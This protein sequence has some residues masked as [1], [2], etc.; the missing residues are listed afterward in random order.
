MIVSCPA[1]ESRFQVDEE[2][3]GYDGRIVRCGKCSNCWHQ[4]PEKDPRAG[5]ADVPPPP[6]RRRAAAPPKKKGKGVLVGWLLLLVFIGGV[7]A[8]GWFERARIVTQFPQLADVYNLLGVPLPESGASL[9]LSN[10]TTSRT[11][12]DGD[13]VI[14]V[15]GQL[16]N[17]SPRK[18]TL[19]PLRIQLSDGAGAVVTE[20]FFDVPEGP[21]DAGETVS[22]E[23]V[24]K[25][26]PAS[27]SSV[28]VT[29]AGQAQ[30]VEE[31]A[32]D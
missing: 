5:L 3:L 8:V 11:A 26:P 28:S 6:P 1:C 15:R 20:W 21:L 13:D 32:A 4:M 30:P 25:N 29:F 12:V 27:A 22:F 14:T 10:V 31:P 2:Q 24:T 17:I 23:T 9:Q 19:P 7:A 16:A 18:Q